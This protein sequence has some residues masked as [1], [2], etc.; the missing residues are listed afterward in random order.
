MVQKV[1][2][3]CTGNSCRSQMAEALWQD[4]GQGHWKAVSA[5]SRP[6][7]Y[8]HPLAIAV[9]AER[10]NDLSSAVSKSLDEFR[11]QEFDIVVTVCDNAREDC[12]VF[13]GAKQILHWPF[14]DPADVTGSE[15]AKLQAFRRIRD[16][17]EAKI[18]THLQSSEGV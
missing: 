18:Q 7:G 3:L 2:V 17:I 16:E 9:M 4:L 15:A 11:E 6:V 14:E 5:G 13:T 8:V 10:G 12:P 1:L